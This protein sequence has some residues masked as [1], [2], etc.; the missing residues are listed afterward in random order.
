MNLLCPNCQQMLTVPDE[1]AGQ[2]MKCSLCNGTFTVPGL[3]GAGPPHASAP[4]P[5]VFTLRPEPPPV[6]PPPP[7]P[8]AFHVELPPPPASTAT[9]PEPAPSLSLPP[10]GYRH[11]MTMWFSPKVLPWIAPVCLLLI[12]FLQLMDW[13]GIYP[14]GVPTVTGNAW[15]AAFGQY[16]ED[17]DLKEGSMQDE[18]KKPGVSVLTI[19]YLLLFFPVLVLTIASVILPMLP[20]K[21][22]PQA[23]KLLPWRWGLVAAANLL[24]LLFL[25]L[26]VLLGFSLESRYNE[27]VEKSLK[28]DAKEKPTTEERKKQEVKEGSLREMLRH[29]FAL[30]LT[31]FLHLVAILSAV[32]MFWI[33][34]RGAHRPEPKL[35]LLW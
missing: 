10:E 34:Q 8:S 30:R 2:L 17:P 15:R 12:F 31:V 25:G 20:L 7:Q 13:V 18:K 23:E 19:F 16:A 11:T 26:Q 27:W 22:P 28:E 24:L 33:N 5:D 35:E 32:L 9:T 3:P 6:A 4:E 21:L 1:F 29:T 14:G